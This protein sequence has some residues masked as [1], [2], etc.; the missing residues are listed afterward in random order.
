MSVA[1]MLPTYNEAENIESLIQEIE[2]LKLDLLIAVVDDSSPDGTAEVLK[3]LQKKYSNIHLISRPEKLGL[4]TAIT[5]GFQWM[6]SLKRQPDHIITMDADY[7]HNPKDIPRLMKV[8][9]R[10]YDLVIGSR[11]CQGGKMIGSNS[12]RRLISRLANFIAAATISMIVNDY[13]SGFRCYSKNYVKTVLPNLHSET[14]EIQIET[15]KQARLR[16]F[17]IKEIPITFLNRK[18]GKS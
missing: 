5:T 17:G 9:K 14:Y 4:G 3:K 8:A 11:Y 1:V 18:R 6:M 13:T 12:R 2:E 7:S 15:L 10:G 16:G